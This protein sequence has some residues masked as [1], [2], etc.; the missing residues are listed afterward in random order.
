M[1]KLVPID[2]TR[3]IFQ[4]SVD[5]TTYRNSKGLVIPSSTTLL[6]LLSKDE[7][8]PWANWL[9]FKKIDVKT[10]VESHAYVGKIAHA[11][12]EEYLL[13]G[14]IGQGFYE[15]NNR[16]REF[17]AIKNSFM[18][19]IKF[20]VPEAPKFKIIR[21]EFSI[22][23]DKF[24]GTLDLLC[25]YNGKLTLAD[26]KTSKSFYMSMFMQMGSYDLLL[27]ETE[28]IEVEQYMII[29]LD[30]KT[31]KPAKV[32]ICDDSEHMQLYRDCFN[33]L[34]ELYYQYHF[35]QQKLWKTRK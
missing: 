23:G 13:H 8:V 16:L 32:M 27:R 2:K 10:E 6:K 20:F 33:S 30:K 1:Y 26:F 7:L 5:H 22:S 17:Q 29:R 28:G 19:F 31:G 9:G 34:V 21:N 12:I 15:H 3:P 35:I 18:S 25:E 24:G 14:T 11:L 4:P